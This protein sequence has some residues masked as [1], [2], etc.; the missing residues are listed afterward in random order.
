[1]DNKRYTVVLNGK[2]GDVFALKIDCVSSGENVMIFDAKSALKKGE[3]TLYLIGDEIARTSVN[4]D[5]TAYKVP[6]ATKSDFACVYRTKGDFFVG[7]TGKT[8]SRTALEKR[9]ISFEKA[10]ENKEQEKRVEEEII[11]PNEDVEIPN[12]ENDFEEAHEENEPT[13]STD[14]DVAVTEK[15]G[16]TQDNKEK[17]DE[18]KFAKNRVDVQKKNPFVLDDYIGY[19]GTNFYLAV[20]PQLDEIFVCYPP[21]KELNELVPNSKWAR[22]SS[23]DESYVVGLV[24]DGD[25][26]AY[27]CYGIPF[28]HYAPAPE[29][30]SDVAVWLPLSD[31]DGRGYWTIYQSA[32]DGRCVGSATTR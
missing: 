27:I 30:I 17:D 2:N 12:T 11:P 31:R 10:L 9:I 7:S 18:T 19:D 25:D 26:V 20:K 14:G 21:E 29:E 23:D 24:K 28:S 6:F 3:G 32:V 4:H 5:K 16:E 1:M 13:A 8:P 22:I 15:E